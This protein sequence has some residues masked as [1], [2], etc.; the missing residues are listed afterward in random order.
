MFSNTFWNVYAIY[1]EMIMSFLFFIFPSQQPNSF[2]VP[3]FR[4]FLYSLPPSPSFSDSFPYLP[5][6]IYSAAPSL[7]AFHGECSL[8]WWCGECNPA[9]GWGFQ[10]SASQ[11]SHCG[12]SVSTV[13]ELHYWR[14]GSHP[15][16]IV[17]NPDLTK[18]RYFEWIGKFL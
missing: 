18:Y 2:F 5:V 4:S 7:P 16:L 10:H 3:S 17:I 8:G 11:R 14:Q 1:F 13:M 12:D 6:L 15:T 9:R